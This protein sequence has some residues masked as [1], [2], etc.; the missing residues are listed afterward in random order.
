[1]VKKKK[2]VIGLI[3]CYT[4]IRPTYVCNK[5]VKRFSVICYDMMLTSRLSCYKV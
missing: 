5:E 2:Y 4:V 1:V 3:L